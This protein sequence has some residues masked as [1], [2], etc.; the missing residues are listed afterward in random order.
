M[1]AQLA[2]VRYRS[3]LYQRARARELGRQVTELRAA[4][5]AVVRYERHDD[6]ACAH[7]H[8]VPGVWNA[9]NAPSRAGH[10][11]AQCVAFL[12]ARRLLGLGD[13]PL[14]EGPAVEDLFSRT[15]EPP[16][17]VELPAWFDQHT[18]AQWQEFRTSE[19]P[20]RLRALL[21]AGGYPEDAFFRRCWRCTFAEYDRI[22]YEKRACARCVADIRTA[23]G[24]PSAPS[25]PESRP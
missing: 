4:L 14:P 24:L 20:T 2:A 5:A 8:D 15:P 19:H 16:A 18:E 1:A 22:T 9:D 6:G 3:P 21:H 11:C 7:E 23:L 13:D 17:S 10:P 25:P 12:T